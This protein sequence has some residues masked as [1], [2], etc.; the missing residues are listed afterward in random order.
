MVNCQNNP[1]PVR[2]RFDILQ[3]F[4]TVCIDDWGIDHIDLGSV[5]KKI[6]GLFENFPQHFPNSQ[7][8]SYPKKLLNHP[9]I[10]PKNYLKFP[11]N[12]HFL[13]IG[14]EKVGGSAIW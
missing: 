11:Q 6:T 14:F 8:L 9:K 10:A 4:K 13:A 2:N 3:L 12:P 1:G 5:H 7:N